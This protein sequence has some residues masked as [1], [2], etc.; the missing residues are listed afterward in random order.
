V[1][2][3]EEGADFVTGVEARYF[4]AGGDDCAGTVGEG[5]YRGGAGKG[6]LSFMREERL[7]IEGLKEGMLINGYW[8]NRRERERERGS[9][10]GM[11]YV[12]GWQEALTFRNNQIAVV[13]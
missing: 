8:S 5:G 6:V 1:C 3:V 4:W 9:A 13:E 11:M 10:K 12:Q 7:A 2:L